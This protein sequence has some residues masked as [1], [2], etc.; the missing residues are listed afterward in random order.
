MAKHKWPELRRRFFT[1]EWLTL[2]A[3]A[4]KT[5][6][7][8]STIRKRAADEKWHD[9]RAVMERE[10]EAKSLA[11]IKERF[12]REAEKRIPTWLDLSDA[13][14]MKALQTLLGSSMLSGFEAIRAAQAAVAIETDIF[15]PSKRAAAPEGEQGALT[16]TQI[17]I[18][19][20]AAGQPA[21]LATPAALVTLT[22]A[23]LEKIYAG[24]GA[25]LMGPRVVDAKARSKRKPGRRR[26]AAK[27]KSKAVV[28]KLRQ[29]HIQNIPRKLA[30]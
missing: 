6:I 22:D 30:P 10:D 25:K 8:I 29:V 5:V 9:R 14:K 23:D 24:E 18:H 19:M 27:A 15:M 17:N 21:R 3:M 1:G 26:K 20:G 28:Q 11:R 12:H 4:E 16:A 13:L 2:E 7:S